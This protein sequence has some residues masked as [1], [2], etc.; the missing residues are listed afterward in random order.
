M[1]AIPKGCRTALVVLAFLGL[2]SVTVGKSPRGTG[3]G[4]VA[5]N[6]SV[7]SMFAAVDE[8]PV[9]GK[10]PLTFMIY[11]RGKPGWH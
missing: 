5:L 3:G 9:S 1:N 4:G 7:T 10:T 2:S 8:R 6:P 11:F